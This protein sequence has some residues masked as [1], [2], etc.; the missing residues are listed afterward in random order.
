[1][2]LSSLLQVWFVILSAKSVSSWCYIVILDGILHASGG[3]MQV[4]AI[5]CVNSVLVLLVAGL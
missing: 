5:V 2:I 3:I 1:M 4:N